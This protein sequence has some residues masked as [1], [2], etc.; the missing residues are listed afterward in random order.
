M[1]PTAQPPQADPVGSITPAGQREPIPHVLQEPPTLPIHLSQSS[2]A[3]ATS[4]VPSHWEPP[5]SVPLASAA[6][7]YFATPPMSR[8]TAPSHPSISGL[9]HMAASPTVAEG[10]YQQSPAYSMP[11]QPSPF[12]LP[13]QRSSQWGAAGV[14]VG[15]VPS[16]LPSAIAG[17]L[18]AVS[19]SPQKAALSGAWISSTTSVPKP[20]RRKTSASVSA[21]PAKKPMSSKT[22]YLIPKSDVER[23]DA[24]VK[25]ACDFAG[26]VANPPLWTT[27]T[28]TEVRDALQ[29]DFR[30]LVNF[31]RYSYR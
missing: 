22:V 30:D 26:L 13:P 5:S 23:L 16:V 3:L 21:A 6:A 27:M 9:L 10:Q 19:T 28:S 7:D 15:R 17:L 25:A 31:R 20:A 11:T 4:A 8:S 1:V 2:N 24:R 29:K 12:D 14:T 18:P